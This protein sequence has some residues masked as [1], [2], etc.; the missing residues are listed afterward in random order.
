MVGTPAYMSPEQ[1][2][3]PSSELDI[4]SD[5]YSLG[6]VL[7]EMLCGLP[8]LGNADV[9]AMGLTELMDAIQTRPVERPSARLQQ[10]LSGQRSGAAF[11]GDSGAD[12]LVHRLNGDLD[13]IVMKALEKDRER[14]YDTAAGLSEDLAAFL[15]NR[16]VTARPPSFRYLAGKFLRR[17]CLA[18]AGA[19]IVIATVVVALVVSVSLLLRERDARRLADLETHRSREVV[20]FLEDTLASVGP[21]VAMGRDTTL[22]KEVLR[23][24]TERIGANLPDSPEI[25]AEIRLI[26]GRTWWSLTESAI[27]EKELRRALDLREKQYPG[28]HPDIVEALS[29][30]T[31]VLMSLGRFR[32]AE[33]TARRSLAMWGN[34]GGFEDPHVGLCQE[35]IAFCLLKLGRVPEAE[36]MSRRAFEM[37]RKQ[38]DEPLLRNAPTVRAS[39]LRQFSSREEAIQIYREELTTKQTL[40]GEEHPHLVNVLDNLGDT[41]AGNRQD[42]EAEEI[43]LRG[44]AMGRKFFGDRNPHED[45]MLTSLAG[46]A[47]RRGDLEE[48]LRFAREAAATGARIYAPDHRYFAESQGQLAR[49][50]LTQAG[51]TLDRA[52]QSGDEKKRQRA[53]ALLDELTESETLMRMVEKDRLWIEVLLAIAKVIPG[54]TEREGVVELVREFI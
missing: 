26:V 21:E 28:D 36:V 41:L 47:G 50:L 45:H 40:Y 46:I 6:A 15:E 32:E 10:R 1:V 48:Q 8:L 24:T 9:A 7:Y 51:T 2:S 20:H 54:K 53:M 22:M 43:L 4:R 38:P 16:P 5:V 49:V 34:L 17:H 39:V 52:W 44:V 19:T 12:A 33:E 30:Y 27:A 25:E 23:K 13:W 18:V 29:S 11:R 42:E 37:W 3:L 31:E 35:Q 14:R